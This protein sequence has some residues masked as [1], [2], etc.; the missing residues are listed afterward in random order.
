MAVAQESDFVAL[1]REQQERVWRVRN[2]VRHLTLAT[3]AAVPEGQSL[4]RGRIQDLI[5]EITGTNL[6][7]SQLEISHL[8]RQS[9]I[10]YDLSSQREEPFPGHR[11]ILNPGDPDYEENMRIATAAEHQVTDEGRV[12]T[13]EQ[14][15]GQ[16]ALELSAAGRAREAELG[17]RQLRSN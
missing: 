14:L 15:V 8:E 4:G 2:I 16:V 10:I 3:I 7:V 1:A 11:Y 6:A 5:R 13:H 12:I 17:R 9:V